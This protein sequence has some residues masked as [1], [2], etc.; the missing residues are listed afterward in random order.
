MEHPLFDNPLGPKLPPFTGS[1]Y[2][3]ESSTNPYYTPDD[4]IMPETI[5]YYNP[6]MIQF[7]PYQIQGG[8]YKPPPKIT[9]GANDKVVNFLLWTGVLILLVSYL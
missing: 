9:W 4:S 3:T 1:V 8:R 2:K 5:D 6:D 7:E